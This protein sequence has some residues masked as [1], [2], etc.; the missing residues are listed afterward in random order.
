MNVVK[1]PDVQY[2]GNVI[3]ASIYRTLSYASKTSFKMLWVPQ[4]QSHIHN[5]QKTSLRHS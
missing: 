4:R 2:D 5:V 1:P 3:L